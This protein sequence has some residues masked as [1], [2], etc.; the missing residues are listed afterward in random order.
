MTIQAPVAIQK[1]LGAFNPAT[2][3]ITGITISGETPYQNIPNALIAPTFP[4]VRLAISAATGTVFTQ[5]KV[6]VGDGLGGTFAFNPADTTSGCVCSGSSAGTVLTVNSVSTGTIVVGQ[7]LASS[8]TG[9]PLATI[10]SFGTGTGGAGTYNLSG[11]VNQPG[12]FTFLLDNNSNILVSAD[13]SRWYVTSSFTSFPGPTTIGPPTSAVTALTVNAA[14]GAVAA[15]FVSDGVNQAV[16]FSAAAG[17]NC[18]QFDSTNPNGSYIVFTRNGVAVAYVGNSGAL[19]GTL[20][21]LGL[22]SQTGIDLLT[23][24]LTHLAM[25][26]SA[27]GNVTVNGPSSG[28]A[29]TVNGSSGAEAL[30]VAASGGGNPLNVNGA[31]GAQVALFNSDQV[32][33]PFMLFTSSGINFAYIGGASSFGG[34]LNNLGLRSQ[35]GIDLLTNGAVSPTVAMNLATSGAISGF[36][37]TAAALV[38]M[39]PDQGSWTTTISGAFAANP[40]GTLKW[41]RVGGLVCVWADATI[42]AATNASNTLSCSGLPA[43]ITPTV[44]RIVES[45]GGFVRAVNCPMTCTITTANTILLAAVFTAN[46]ANPTAVNANVANP[47]DTASTAGI[48]AGWVIWYPL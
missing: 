36:G 47:F 3:V 45:W 30:H 18:A 24:G 44:N 1:I 39:T 41:R 22:R 25:K 21:N 13:G 5:G 17:S 43:A 8:V 11:T 32:N 46:A 23:S 34:T 35:T 19:G 14:T 2:G 20:D 26:L 38:D 12:P 16:T 42:S 6:T 40:T 27:A 31:T 48:F 37:P 15:R 4:Q 29:L 9:L 33:G 28:I 10:I 7:T